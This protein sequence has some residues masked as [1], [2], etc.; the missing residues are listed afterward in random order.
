MKIKIFCRCSFCLSWS[1]KELISTSVHAYYCRWDKMDALICEHWSVIQ[2]GKH[3]HTMK[4]VH[5]MNSSCSRSVWEWK[6]SNRG[7]LQYVDRRSSKFLQMLTA[8]Q[9]VQK[10]AEG[11][12]PCAPQPGP[13][14]RLIKKNLPARGLTKFEKHWSTLFQQDYCSIITHLRLCLKGG[15]FPS[16]IHTE[17]LYTFLFSPTCSCPSHLIILY[18]ITP[19]FGEV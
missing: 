17:T 1:C 5:N 10:L 18:L 2:Q 9:V 13:G 11:A 6:Q 7:G 14:H 8:P 4:D 12:R 3:N 19:I 15:L 16:N